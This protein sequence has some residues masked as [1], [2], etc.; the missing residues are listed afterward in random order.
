MKLDRRTLLRGIGAAGASLAFAGTA[1]ATGGEA[2]YVVVA[3]GRGVANRLEDAGFEVSQ[4]LADGEVLVVHGPAGAAEELAGVGGVQGATRDVRLELV[5]PAE[6]E[7]LTDAVGESDWYENLWDKQRTESLEANGRATG[8]GA[9]IAIL[10]TGIDYAHPDLAGNLN[11]EA[12]RLFREGTVY[13]GDEEGVAVAN[14]DP[15]AEIQRVDHHVASDVEGHGTHV[16]GIAA[17][18]PEV[19]VEGYGTGVQ[20]VAPA[21]DL[22]SYRVFWW[23]FV[24][25]DDDDEDEEGEWVLTT[26]TADVLAAIDR[27]AAEGSDAANLSLGTSPFQ[28]RLLGDAELRTLKIAYERTVSAAV[29]RGTVVVASA[30]NADTSLQQG[31]LFSLPNSTQGAMSISALGPDDERSYYSNVGTNEIDVGAPGGA[32]GTELETLYG[33]REWIFAGQ[34]LRR[35]D[36]PLEEGDDGELWFDED[37]DLTF[38]PEAVE[39]V[40]E[41]T[42]PAW[43]YPF[44]LVFSATSPLVEG[45]PYDWKAGTSMAAPQ[46][47]GLV[48][49]VR[50]LDPDATPTRVESAIK[51]GATGTSGRSDPAL[52]A[53]RIDA[54]RTLEWID[55]TGR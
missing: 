17:A 20:G 21:A 12:G 35:S 26:T 31:G 25:P 1:S 3:N 54:V 22:I 45:V 49:L 47:A 30:G 52:G 33:V 41:F 36:H 6:S 32:Y 48:A 19:G 18:D 37:G 29:Q 14:P 8:D 42:S 38:D 11:A 5:Q 27:A 7:S 34:P 15:T 55:G 43:P 2:Q 40:V 10:D 9:E 51:Q 44:N 39:E 50:D 46:V 53:G 16:A 28:P 24:E 4:T 23:E 13:A